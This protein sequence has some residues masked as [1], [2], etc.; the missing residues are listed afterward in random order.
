MQI[1]I[2]SRSKA[3]KETFKDALDPAPNIISITDVGSKDNHFNRFNHL[4]VCKFDDIDDEDRDG[5]VYYNAP[6]EKDAK[7]IVNFIRG[8]DDRKLIVHCEAGICRSSATAIGAHFIK[9]GSEGAKERFFPLIGQIFPNERLA[10]LIDQEAGLNGQML[11][12]CEAINRKSVRERL[13][14]T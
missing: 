9:F 5:L 14:N 12:F 10:R 4:L 6:T 2:L 7:R 1:L 11:L 8:I 13:E 3:R